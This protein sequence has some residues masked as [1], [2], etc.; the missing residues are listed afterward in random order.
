[1]MEPHFLNQVHPYV[2]LSRQEEWKEA[3]SNYNEA[4]KI[5]SPGPL[6]CAPIVVSDD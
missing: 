6:L 4:Q 5:G 1:M 2:L 3:M